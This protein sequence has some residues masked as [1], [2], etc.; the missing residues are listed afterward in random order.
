MAHEWLQAH[1]VLAP[2]GEVEKTALDVWNN[3]YHNKLNI[4]LTDTYTTNHF[5]KNIDK[6]NLQ[7]Y[8]GRQD[9]GD[10][11]EWGNKMLAK[12]KEYG[13][14]HTQKSLMFS[15]GLNFPKAICID[16]YFIDK[17]VKSVGFGIGTDLTNDVGNKALNIVVKLVK[18]NNFPTIKISDDVGKT[19]CEDENFKKFAIEF[20][21]K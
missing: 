16:K 4:A 11:L 5:L 18:L 15:D 20:F 8:N 21:T 2:I 14:D 13:I 1:I 7:R 10:P 12:Y 17:G 3:I 19:I 6:T 9:S